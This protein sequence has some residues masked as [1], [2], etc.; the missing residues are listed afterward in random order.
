MTLRG[1][2]LLCPL[3]PSRYCCILSF[4]VGVEDITL[5]GLVR[6][7]PLTPFRYCCILSFDGGVEGMIAVSRLRWGVLHD[8]AG[9]G[10]AVP[11]HSRLARYRCALSFW[12]SYTRRHYRISSHFVSEP[13][14]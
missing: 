1:L 5:R 10:T 11:C 6:S 8:A 3:P 13:R 12:Y 7:S 4:D 14:V 9:S 2:V